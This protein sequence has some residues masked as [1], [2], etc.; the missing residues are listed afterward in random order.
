[1]EFCGKRPVRSKL[2]LD[3]QLVEQVSKFNC[4]GCQLSYKGEADVSH[5]LEK[6]NFMCSTIK[7]TLKNKTRIETQFKF[8]KVM[9]ISAYVDVT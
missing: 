2:I 5:K 8:Y 6:L 7:L 1:M 3:N 4:L 9:V